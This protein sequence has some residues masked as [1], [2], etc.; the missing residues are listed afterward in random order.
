[1]TTRSDQYT[2]L[3]ACARPA[4]A[5]VV[6]NTSVTDRTCTIRTRA[7][8]LPT[9]CARVKISVIMLLQSLILLRAVAIA[10]PRNPGYVFKS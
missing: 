1:M 9:L 5:W 10:I 7:G 2:L 4:I 3:H 6:G 8:V